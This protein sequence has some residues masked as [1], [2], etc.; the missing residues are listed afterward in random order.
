MQ[1][2][3]VIN[4]QD[5]CGRQV[6]DADIVSTTDV[7]DGLQSIEYLRIRESYVVYMR[8]AGWKRMDIKPTPPM[9]ILSTSPSSCS[10]DDFQSL[11]SHVRWNK[12]SMILSW[13]S[14]DRK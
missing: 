7:P 1:E 14:M 9:S 5:L 3:L 6:G 12:G 4:V 8:S 2:Q 10:E 11:V 13:V